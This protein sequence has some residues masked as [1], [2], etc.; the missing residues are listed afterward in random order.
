MKKILILLSLLSFL[1][2]NAQISLYEQANALYQQEQ[3]HEAEAL[4]DSVIT[5]GYISAELY[6]NLGNAQYQNGKIAPC[7]LSYERALQLAP[8][9]EDINY[10]LELVQ[11]HVIDDIEEVDIFFLKK[12]MYNMRVS[13]SSDTWGIISLLCFF[14]GALSL[15]FF[16]LS[17]ISF[18]KRTG[19]YLFIIAFVF[20]LT[21]LSFARK[22]KYEMTSHEGAIVLVPTVT[23]KSSPNESGTQIF[24]IHEGTKVKI[25]DYLNDWVEIMLS[26][27][28][29]GW[30]K[31]I[32]IEAI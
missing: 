22:S 2:V 14:I 4:Y 18:L 19:F 28:H 13:Q 8:T 25:T 17:R 9:D 24:V 15:V 26:D 12:M 23:V 32:T 31:T 16:F 7:I 27:G 21:T 11:Q 5:S 10:N 30:V 3:Y 1:S 29:K 6:Y 20:S